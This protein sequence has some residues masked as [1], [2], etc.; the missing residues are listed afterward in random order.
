MQKI[1]LTGINGQVGHVLKTKLAEYEELSQFE[2]LALSREQLDLTKTHDIR[3][4]VR[5]VKPSLIINPAAY[6]A[7]DKAESEPE[8]AYAI[9]ATAAQ[10]LAEEAAR[11]GAGLIHFST[12]YVY[13]GSKKAPYVETDE[14]NPVSVYGKSKLAG[15]D[16]IRAVDLPHLILRTSWVYGAYGKNFLKTILRLA[17]ERDSLRIVSDQFG[18]PTSSESIAD[19]LVNLVNIWQPNQESQS[20]VYHL[21]NAGEASWHGFSCKIVN[22]YNHLAASKAWPVLKA[23]VDSI[24]PISSADYPTPAARPANSRLNNTKLKQFGNKVCSR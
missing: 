11:L 15:E 8:L 24:A 14:V 20:G 23:S 18:A 10:I 3:R 6:T 1:L 12:D 9:N 4:I 17:A 7:V 19:A 22:E 2:I 13:D 21:T 5:E 16:S